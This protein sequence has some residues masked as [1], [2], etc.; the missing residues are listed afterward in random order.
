MAFSRLKTEYLLTPAILL[1]LCI[2]WAIAAPSPDA[3]GVRVAPNPKHYSALRWYQEQ[4]FKGSPQSLIIDGYEAIRDGRTVYI[5]ASNIVEGAPANSQLTIGDQ[6]YTNIF[7]ISYNQDAEKS[8]EDIFGQILS[9]WK[10][11]NNINSVGICKGDASITSGCGDAV[12]CWPLSNDYNDARKNGLDGAGSNVTI[13]NGSTK[14]NGVNSQIN[15]GDRPE[16]KVADKFSIV[17]NIFPTGPGSSGGIIVNKEGEYEV[18]R[19][20]DGTIRWAIAAPGVNGG[21]TT[22]W[23]WRNTGFV[24]PLNQWTSIVLTL[25]GNSVITYANGEEVHRFDFTGSSVVGDVH[26]NWNELRIGARDPSMGQYFDGIIGGVRLYKRTLE[27]QEITLTFSNSC[28]VD[29]DCPSAYYCS[30]AKGVLGRDTKRLADLNDLNDLLAAYKT[31]NGGLCPK[32]ESGSYLPNKSISTWPSWQ[33]TL[34]K[35]LGANLPF[36]PINKM[37]DCAGFNVQTCWNETTRSFADPT[38]ADT[39]FDLPDGSRA[40]IYL[41]S[42]NGQQCSFYV[43]TESGLNC[44]GSGQCTVGVNLGSPAPFGTPSN[45][46]SATNTPPKILTINMPTGIRYA[47][48]QG[49]IQAEDADNDNL[50]WT[51]TTT[52]DWSTW[53]APTLQTSPANKYQ[54]RLVSSKS[55]D[56]GNYTFDVSVNDGRGGIAT[57][58]GVIRVGNYCDDKDADGFGVCP[59]CGKTRGCINDG[60]DCDDTIGLHMVTGLYGPFNINGNQINPGQPDDCTQ[61][62]GLDNDCDN[63]VDGHATTSIVIGSTIQDMENISLAAKPFGMFH[64]EGNLANSGSQAMAP[65]GNGTYSFTTGH[66]GQGLHFTGTDQ[67]IDL[68]NHGPNWPVS[69]IMAWVRPDSYQHNAQPYAAVVQIN[70]NYL[71]AWDDS[72]YY[73]YDGYPLAYHAANHANT[74]LPLNTWSHIAMTND[75]VNIRYYLNG[76]FDGITPTPPQWNNGWENIRIG[77]GYVGDLETFSGDID[78]VQIHKEAL[79]EAKIQVAYQDNTVTSAF[80]SGWSGGGQVSSFVGISGKENH[81]S[82]GTNS[83]LL[84]QDANRLYG[85]TCTQAICTDPNFA[86]NRGCMWDPAGGGHCYFPA[87]DGAHDSTIKGN[88]LGVDYLADYNNGEAIAWGNTNTVMWGYMA[89]DLSTFPFNVGDT[90]ILNYYYKGVSRLQNSTWYSLSFSPGWQSYCYN[91]GSIINWAC[92]GANG[93]F[94]GY[95]TLPGDPP[96]CSDYNLFGINWPL[97]NSCTCL[98]LKNSLANQTDCYPSI[99]GPGVPDNTYTDWTYY[100]RSFFFSNDLNNVKNAAGNRQL[101]FGMSFGYNDTTAGTD[102]YVDDLSLLKC[103]NN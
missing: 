28:S 94:S 1:S 60:N 64:F 84:H 50:N 82:S 73:L 47:P 71:A 66:D 83:M 70:N 97:A 91:Q 36:D 92:N 69:T 48:Y 49:F 40:Y 56:L 52:G 99:G 101:I 68:G 53:V 62:D 23:A 35:T 45:P 42:P 31:K 75:G 17:A 11:N 54:R 98:M 18:A 90:Y 39:N 21:S 26:T 43:N 14:F 86:A 67:Y 102:I 72:A 32:L 44:N 76:Q 87:A 77:G 95:R 33:E 78:E 15:M 51:L 5:D 34:G 46:G 96:N 6:L 55:G 16:F 59:N 100:A 37:G 29:P 41:S 30:A 88:Y 93:A 4:G 8:T 22:T 20:A 61:Y 7:I 3:I 80:P 65:T 13:S 63:R 103:N 27:H 12:G 19:Y 24:A 25:S 89:Y 2:G 74:Q 10:F 38:P 57:S 79:V 9:N 81:S 85:G 58:S